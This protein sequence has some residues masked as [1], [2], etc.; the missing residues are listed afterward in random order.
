MLKICIDAALDVARR[1]SATDE[2]SNRIIHP[3]TRP[4][5]CRCRWRSWPTQSC[6][7]RFWPPLA[8]FPVV[9]RRP[10]CCVLLRN[11]PTRSLPLSAAPR[12]PPVNTLSGPAPSSASR[13]HVINQT[14]PSEVLMIAPHDSQ[15]DE[16]IVTSLSGNPPAAVEELACAPNWATSA[17]GLPRRADGVGTGGIWS[18]PRWWGSG[19]RNR[20]PGR[21]VDGRSLPAIAGELCGRNGRGLREALDSRRD[22][23]PRSA[24]GGLVFALQEHHGVAFARLDSVHRSSNA[25]RVFLPPARA[26]PVPSS[27][28]P[29]ESVG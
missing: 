22:H 18:R 17:G 7:A 6:A 25:D 4:T 21:G 9:R 1:Q 16:R 14:S 12:R 29:A 5:A 2:T 10:S 24:R 3:V 28:Q 23:G 27:R 20:R 19:D 26:D 15:L 11:C 8:G 13:W